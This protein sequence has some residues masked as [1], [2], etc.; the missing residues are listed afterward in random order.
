MSGFVGPPLQRCPEPF[1]SLLPACLG[2]RPNT[3]TATNP[4]ARWL[5]LGRRAGQPMTSDTLELRFRRLGLPSQRGRT[6][7]SRHLVLQAPAP[8]IARMLDYRD[9]TTTQL[10]AESGGTSRHYAPAITHGEIKPSWVR[11][12][13]TLGYERSAS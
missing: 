11:E 8:V 9:D 4:D 1:T 5:F 3:M 2:Q 7:A 13:A 10:A 6:P 12:C